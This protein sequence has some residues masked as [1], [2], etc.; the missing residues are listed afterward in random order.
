MDLMGLAI[1]G[2][3]VVFAYRYIDGRRP[4]KRERRALGELM[5]DCN[6]DQELVER[7]IFA[8]MEHHPEMNFSEAARRARA[9]LARDRK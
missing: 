5:E 1:V 8:E 6:G 9:R 4:K 7:L 2:V 3:L